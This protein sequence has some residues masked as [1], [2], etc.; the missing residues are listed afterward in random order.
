MPGGL[1]PSAPARG[2][3]FGH[4]NSAVGAPPSAFLSADGML[5]NEL[6]AMF[7]DGNSAR[8]ST[9]VENEQL[10]F[11]L[12]DLASKVEALEL[13]LKQCRDEQ[14]S[15]VVEIEGQYFPGPSDW[16]AYYIANLNGGLPVDWHTNFANVFSFAIFCA[17]QVGEL[18]LVTEVSLDE[19]AT[20]S[21][22]KTPYG[23]LFV[24]GF[25]ISLI[26]QLGKSIS[27]RSTD[28]ADDSTSN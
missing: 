4:S 23:M 16:R 1:Q 17:K 28:T 8:T 3:S 14:A 10:Q 5:G 7:A 2:V 26:P 20:K 21:K 27:A 24:K 9:N 22:H 13:G 12:A 11:N 19:K 6:D 15:E 18:D 25:Q